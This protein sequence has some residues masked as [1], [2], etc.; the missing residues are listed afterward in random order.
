MNIANV[1]HDKGD[2]TEELKLLLDALEIMDATSSPYNPNTL[3]TVANV[4]RAYASMGDPVHAYEY[5]ARVD[6]MAEKFI[7]LNLATGSEREKLAFIEL[8]RNYN[9]RSIWMSISEAPTDQR[10]VDGA[11]TAIL[12]RKA[13]VLDAL[14]ESVGTLRSHLKPEDQQLLDQ[15]ASTTADLAKLS[16]AGP[17]K[18]A[19]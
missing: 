12:Q 8:L 9:E 17:R 1:E 15:L 11:A 4:A 6:K 18:T 2:F 7:S 16:L 14:A 13:R 10:A 19:A 3:K 5:Q